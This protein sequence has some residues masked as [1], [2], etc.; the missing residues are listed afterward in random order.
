M[1]LAELHSNTAPTQ[2]TPAVTNICTA[3][4]L[5]GQNNHVGRTTSL[6]LRKGSSHFGVNVTKRLVKPTCK[7]LR[8]LVDRKRVLRFTARW[9]GGGGGLT[10][11]LRSWSRR[12]KLILTSAKLEAWFSVDPLWEGKGGT[13]GGEEGD[14]GKKV[15]LAKSL[16]D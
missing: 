6:G 14:E 15:K 1:I 8:L 10:T 3:D 12:V 11:E 16:E 5:L 7:E 13:R 4:E 9:K 2:D